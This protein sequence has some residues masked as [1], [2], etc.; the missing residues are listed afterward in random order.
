MMIAN[1]DKSQ[2]RIF[3]LLKAVTELKSNEALTFDFENGVMV[4]CLV[5]DLEAYVVSLV[6]D[7]FGSAVLD[8]SLSE[9][10]DFAKSYVFEGRS[11]C[12]S[13][14]TRWI[15]NRFIGFVAGYLAA[16]KYKLHIEVEP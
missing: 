15:D 16:L 6:K 2:I 11:C 5:D 8:K 13:D 3:E 14:T 10:L 9:A 4:D 1:T 7:K 12:C